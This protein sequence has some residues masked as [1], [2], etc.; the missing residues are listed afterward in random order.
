ME[1]PLPL[2]TLEMYTPGEIV[3]SRRSLV[4]GTFT[5]ALNGS[6]AWISSHN[7]THLRV[8]D[9][10]GTVVFDKPVASSGGRFRLEH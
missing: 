9:E 10:Q 4:A 2:F 6:K 7:A 3:E 5:D 1:H 8:V